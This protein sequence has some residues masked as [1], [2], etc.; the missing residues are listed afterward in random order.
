MTVMTKPTGPLELILPDLD[1]VS[2]EIAL[3]DDAEQEDDHRVVP[4]A[5][6]L[7]ELHSPPG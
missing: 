3:F 7:H 4:L 1:H 6:Y 5:R 2:V